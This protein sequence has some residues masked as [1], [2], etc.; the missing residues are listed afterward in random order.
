MVP[1]NSSISF[2]LFFLQEVARD[3]QQK[4][5]GGTINQVRNEMVATND[6]SSVQFRL[7]SLHI[8]KKYIHT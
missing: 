8:L 7:K 4:I 6:S 1:Q 2:F 5:F 3:F